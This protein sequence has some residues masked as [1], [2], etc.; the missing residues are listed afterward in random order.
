MA[1]TTKLQK[2]KCGD[3]LFVYDEAGAA[4]V[5]RLIR[6]RLDRG[7]MATWPDGTKRWIE[8]AAVVDTTKQAADQYTWAA[9]GNRV[10]HTRSLCTK[11][12]DGRIERQTLRRVYKGLD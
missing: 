4:E 5:M 11:H 2:A 3:T 7:E 12:P 8:D 6:Q 9:D 1:T 10:L